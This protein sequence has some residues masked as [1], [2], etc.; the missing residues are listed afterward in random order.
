MS[1]TFSAANDIKFNASKSELLVFE[2]DPL[3][4]EKQHIVHD[5]SVISPKDFVRH[6]GLTLGLIPKHRAVERCVY[7]FNNKANMFL[8]YFRHTLNML[9][10]A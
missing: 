3:R 2:A 5:N 10:S 9:L 8:S 1:N 4:G 6:L 7:D